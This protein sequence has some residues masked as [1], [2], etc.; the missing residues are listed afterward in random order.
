MVAGAVVPPRV[1][2]ANED[3]LRAHVHAVWLAE[4]RASLG[5]SLREILD[6]ATDTPTLAVLPDLQAKLRDPGARA[7]THERARSALSAAI[8][9][10]LEGTETVDTWLDTALRELP[11]RFERGTLSAGGSSTAAIA[12]PPGRTGS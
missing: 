4:S 11:R 6:C 9:E 8:A 1:D 12:R 7:R 2:L 3:L 10:V 5:S